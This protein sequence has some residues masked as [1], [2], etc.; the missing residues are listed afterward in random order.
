MNSFGVFIEKSKDGYF[1][2]IPAIRGCYVQGET[3]E[4]FLETYTT[5]WT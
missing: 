3:Y 5:F 1:A 2:H 4:G